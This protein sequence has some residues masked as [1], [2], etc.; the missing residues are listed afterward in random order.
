MPIYRIRKNY[1]P[2]TEI[3]N[4][5]S[6][7]S[8]DS[9][10]ETL[11]SAYKK[12]LCC[13]VCMAFFAISQASAADRANTEKRAASSPVLL[14]FDDADL[15]EVIR[16][17]AELLELNYIINPD[18]RGKVTIHT[19]GKLKKK[20]LFPVF[21]QI[22][23]ANGLIAV[24]EGKLWKINSRK[25][26]SRMT[27][28]PRTAVSGPKPG[29]EEKFIIQIIP[30]QFVSGAEMAKLLTPFVTKD[31]TVVAH[32]ESKTLLVVD[33][34]ANIH[35]ILKLIAVFDVNIFETVGHRFFVLKHSDPEETAKTLKDIFSGFGAGAEDKVKFV[36]LNRLNAILVVGDDTRLFDKVGEFINRLDTPVDDTESRI[37]IYSVK[38]GEAEELAELLNNVFSA[39]E[40]ATA[41]ED[42]GDKAPKAEPAGSSKKSPFGI[43]PAKEKKGKATPVVESGPG[44]SGTLKGNIRIIPDLV[45]NVLVI[46]A[47]PRDYEIIEGILKRLDVLPKQVLIEVTLAEI[48]LDDKTELGLEWTY[49]KGSGDKID[50]SLIEAS[51]GAE[52]LSYLIGESYRLT[53]AITALASDKKVNILSA[54]SVLASDNKAA[55]INISTEIPV[56]S[57]QIRSDSTTTPITETTIQYRNTGVILNVTPHINEHGLVSMEISQEVSETSD[58]VQVG[59]E[60]MPSFFK[61]SVNTT[62]TVM[63]GQ[64]IVIGGLIR[65]TKTDSWSGVPCMG[66]IPVIEYLFGKKSVSGD[67]TELIIMITPRVIATL[68]DVDAVT[69]EFK[70]KVKNIW[71]NEDGA[72]ES[73]QNAP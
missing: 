28:T 73:E 33:K 32:G 7:F 61:R 6:E 37:Y 43:A 60:S 47:M 34:I 40:T 4:P 3:R 38:N 48:T 68:D 64:T 50:T 17:F 13:L 69:K 19:S 39:G 24:K 46:E 16:T 41:N 52:G 20:D 53:N 70:N 31:G 14:N 26:G 49:L 56:A 65:G 62:L 54:P 18:I 55:T 21:N 5:K 15:Y 57:A 8:S 27:I 66:G 23:E 25:E 2:Q 72:S 63:D 22:L 30:L 45:R 36:A 42:K 51:A 71:E 29:E 35:K 67:K 58:S 44:D 11:S 59:N 10:R 12:L 1:N 9:E